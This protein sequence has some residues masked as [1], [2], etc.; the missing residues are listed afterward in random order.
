[1]IK[2]NKRVFDKLR[3]RTSQNKHDL[4]PR[5]IATNESEK[6][7]LRETRFHSDPSYVLS[8][9][10]A[11]YFAEFNSEIY[12][13]AKGIQ[14]KA[15]TDQ[16]TLVVPIDAGLFT[17]IVSELPIGV[18]Q[19]ITDE[20][21]VEKIF[22]PIEEADPGPPTVA[23]PLHEIQ[24]L[25]EPFDVY[26]V[27][28]DSPLLADNFADRIALHILTTTQT[29]TPLP[30]RRATLDRFSD[31]TITPA[32]NLPHRLLLRTYLENRWDQAFLDI[33]RCLEQLFP[34]ARVGRLIEKINLRMARVQA[35]DIEGE[36]P[37]STER[38]EN[39]LVLYELAELTE[40]ILGWR[41]KED[42]AICE[43][44]ESL[45]PKLLAE[46]FCYFGID[47]NNEK[48]AARA[49]EQLYKMRNRAVHF[50]P[51]HSAEPEPSHDEW[52]CATT[53]LIK[54]VCSL[55]ERIGNE[56]RDSSPPLDAHF[57]MS[58]I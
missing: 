14:R 53:W 43:L 11:I 55:Y 57:R 42:D 22:F 47:E 21:L 6:M 19:H 50:R 40:S 9:S 37:T 1:M 32:K 36:E 31:A 8:E 20:Y 3:F 49:A 30:F 26:R 13:I 2:A 52:E 39:N 5:F 29:S 12:A 45:E 41:A 7:K 25:F 51:I 16:L 17:A 28:P 10:T 18:A 33:Y 46:I 38:Q 58:I 15:A 44:I 56:L 48:A 23:Y 27:H 35:A 4:I 24:P 54:A 34:L